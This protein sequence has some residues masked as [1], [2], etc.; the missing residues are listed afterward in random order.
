MKY[1]YILNLTSEFVQLANLAGPQNPKF[2]PQT[3]QKHDIFHYSELYIVP[4]SCSKSWCDVCKDSVSVLC[5]PLSLQWLYCRYYYYVR[6]KL[7]VPEQWKESASPSLSPYRRST[8]Q[9][10]AS[11]V[12]QVCIFCRHV[13]LSFAAWRASII[14]VSTNA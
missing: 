6:Y 12:F 8:T 9:S 2:T 11:W 14:R 5:P 1:N 10:F 3:P 13:H 7:M 4:M